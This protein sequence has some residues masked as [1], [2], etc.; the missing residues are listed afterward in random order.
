M[1]G[2]SLRSD[3]KTCEPTCGG[4]IKASNGS[5]QSPNFPVRYEPNT[6]CTWELEAEEGHQII[7]NFTHF[8]VEGL[9]TECAYDYVKIGKIAGSQNEFEKFCGDYHEPFVVTSL[10]NRLRITFMSDSSVEKTGFGAYFLTDFDECQYGQHQCDHICV[11]TIGSYKCHCESGFVLAPDGHN[12]KEG[13]CSF[14]LND[15]S[16]IITSPNF[17][18]E[19]SN[20]KRCQW[21]FVTT[22][23][24]RLAL[25]FDEFV[26]EEDRSC[27]YDR[28][29]VFDGG[30]S[31]SGVLGAFCG[32]G[33]PP[34]LVS[35]SNQLFVVMSSDSTVTRRGFRAFYESECGGL[36]TAERSV[37]YVYSHARYSDNKYD[38]K[39]N[40]RW[41]IS[42]SD[43]KQGVELR[44]TQF[45]V[46]MGTSCEYDYVAIYDGAV[47]T[48]NNKFGQFCGDKIPPVVV[49]TSH[50]VI[51]EFVTDDSVEQKGFVLEYRATAPSGQRNRFSPSVYSPREFIV[52]NIQ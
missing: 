21:H 30:D 43:R 2:Y 25:T 11:N 50:S 26:L 51:V 41:V 39:L 5:F 45:A 35:T 40:C 10:S 8:N 32:L 47:A 29:E 6:E 34:K 42:S 3:G 9:K 13:G 37:G 38:K 18:D 7:V 24:H 23:G 31:R 49:S 44:F 20:F 14:Q 19:Y 15:P 48:E 12:C 28:V 27:S 17:P 4:H 16:G 46:E 52:N 1:I 33:K 36:L 22:P